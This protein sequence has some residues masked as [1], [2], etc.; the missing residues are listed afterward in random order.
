M[1]K[2]ATLLLLVQ[3][4][5]CCFPLM[6]Q[7][8][9]NNYLSIYDTIYLH[10]D[11][12]GEKY[13]VHTMQPDQTLYSL[14]KFYGLHVEDLY[15]H[16]IGLRERNYEIGSP[17]KIPIPNRAIVRYR[18]TDFNPQK[19]IPVYYVVKRGD[20]MFRISKVLFRMEVDEMLA[21]NGLETANISPGQIL[22]VGWMSI[23]GI[24]ESFRQGGGGPLARR[25]LAMKSIYRYQLNG[26]KPIP[27]QGVAYWKKDS[28]DDGD[29]YALHDKAPINSVISI[30][31]PM[32]R[33]TLYAKVIGRLPNTDLGPNVKVVI[34]PLSAKFLGA[35][36][37]RFFV[38]IN[39]MR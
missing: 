26:R 12:S 39:Y 32:T 23:E 31:N 38:K 24:P 5:L 21:R 25:N 6:S 27:S 20:T 19:F 7:A 13:H 29:F 3:W 18:D 10:S 2:G 14:A 28:P 17:I 36:D 9:I 34:S 1:K 11:Y 4:T 37:P 35:K 8:D 30:S 16:N 15:Y 22:H 33:R